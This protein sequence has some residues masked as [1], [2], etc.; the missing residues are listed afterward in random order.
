MT[1][2]P[3]T[4]PTEPTEAERPGFPT[5]PT[6]D[7]AKLAQHA[8]YCRDAA[9]YRAAGEGHIALAFDKR[10]DDYAEQHGLDVP[11]SASFVSQRPSDVGWEILGI[12]PDA[13]RDALVGWEILGIAPDALRDALAHARAVKRGA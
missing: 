3:T 4:E 10:A 13:L 12:A 2:E 6:R 5:A 9:H 11:P 1:T 8:R 7:P